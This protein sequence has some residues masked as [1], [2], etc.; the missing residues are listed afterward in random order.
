MSKVVLIAFAMLIGAPS[1]S[2]AGNCEHSWQ[3]ASDG[4]SCGGRA[5]DQKTGGKY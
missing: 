5:D 1:L 4:S 3:R 2:F